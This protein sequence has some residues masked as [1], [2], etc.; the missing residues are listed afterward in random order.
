[1]NIILVGCEFAGKTTLA[2]LLLRFYDVTQGR[3]TIDG[4][5]L[6]D[7]TLDS[8]ASQISVVLQEPYLFSG[9][10]WA[11]NSLVRRLAGR[12]L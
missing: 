10:V 9:T 7:V 8:L 5:D 12:L 1:M 11:G 3:I 6:R 2:S 4:C